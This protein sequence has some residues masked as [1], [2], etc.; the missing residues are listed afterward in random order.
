[1]HGLVFDRLVVMFTTTTA[2][3]THLSNT[4]PVVCAYDVV[5]QCG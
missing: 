1:M 2:H 3:F 5:Q 4:L